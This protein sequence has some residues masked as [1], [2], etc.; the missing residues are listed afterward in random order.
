MLRQVEV[1]VSPVSVFAKLGK[2]TMRAVRRR[3]GACFSV[4][5]S[6]FPL[7][8]A[9]P[10]DASDAPFHVSRP[11]SGLGTDA[12]C[13]IMRRKGAQRAGGTQRLSETRPRS[14]W[15]SS[16]HPVDRPRCLS[17][18]LACAPEDH[19]A[20]CVP[21]SAY[22]ISVRASPGSLRASRPVVFEPKNRDIPA[23]THADRP[24]I[25]VIRIRTGF[26]SGRCAPGPPGRRDRN[27]RPN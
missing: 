22:R 7:R 11:A 14:D 17:A 25:P 3:F 2:Q 1:G 8:G 20:W 6:D 27:G 12:A 19:S 9:S 15:L 4:W 18:Q 21:E 13:P 16:D 26:G 5:H 10:D 23:G 24:L